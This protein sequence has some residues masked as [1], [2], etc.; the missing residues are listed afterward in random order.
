MSSTSL[1]INYNFTAANIGFGDVSAVAE[2]DIQ[3]SV[4][5]KLFYFQLDSSYNYGTNI[6]NYGI[7]TSF[8][9]NIAFY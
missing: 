3:S 6:I 9:F 1:G 2:Y 5:N 7:N 4:L 8:K